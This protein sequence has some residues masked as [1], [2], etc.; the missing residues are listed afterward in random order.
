LEWHKT[1]YQGLADKAGGKQGQLL[2]LL[3]RRWEFKPDPKDIG[4]IHQWYQAGTGGPWDTIDT[5]LYWQ[6]QGYQDHAGWGLAGK[7]WYRTAFD[8]PATVGNKPVWLTLGAVYNRGVWIW[9]NGVLQVFEK[10]PHW[11]LGHHDVRTPIDIDVTEWIRPGKTNHVAVLVHTD[12][13]GRN[14]RGGLHRRAFLWTAR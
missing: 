14:P 11:R 5:T 12:P 4:V 10:S 7:A 1:A 8:L 6:A 13:P 2:T 9:V 3:P